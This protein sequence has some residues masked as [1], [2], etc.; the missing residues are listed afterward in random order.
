MTLL[1]D[2][3]LLIWIGQADERLTDEVVALVQ[4]EANTVLFSAVSL[5]EITIKAGLGKAEFRVDPK[6]LRRR[7]LANG[8]AELAFTSEHAVAVQ[9]LPAIH[10]DPFDRAL[11]AQAM[12]EG[13]TLL[14]ADAVVA[15]Y[16][17]LMRKV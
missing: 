13:I 7:L 6:I 11:V 12:V 3:H 17:G 10:S 16:P 4:N 1:L 15:R 9:E 14:T 2:S 8:Y 5:W